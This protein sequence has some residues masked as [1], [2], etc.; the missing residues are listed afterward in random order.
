MN[1]TDPIFTDADAART[2]LESLQ[3]ANGR[4]CPHCG[5]VDN[6]VALKGKSTR[7]GVYKCRDCR[8]P[9]SVTVGTLFERSH[10]PLNKWLLAVHLLCSSKKGISSHQLMRSLGVTYKT[11]WFM[12]HRIR[13]AMRD[14]TPFPMGGEGTPVEVDEA[15]IGFDPDNMPQE[16]KQTRTGQ[17]MKV[18][19]L[20]DRSSGRAKSFV[21]DNLQIG[22]LWPILDA[23][24]AREA[25]VMT[26]AAKWYGSIFWRWNEHGVVNH[27]RDEYV[28]PTDRS[29]HTNTIEGY[30]SIF[31]RGMRGVY[32]HCAKRH[33]HRYLAEFDF[34][35]TNRMALGIDDSAR[36]AKVLSL[37]GGKRLTYRRA[38]GLTCAA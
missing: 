18:L 19:S 25:R 6:S 28:S 13:E 37:I 17:K 30:F 24:I 4:V 8:K 1:L 33:L 11:A 26:D 27:Q 38:D 31:K 14:D 20:V 10:V 32:Q 12:A 9:F 15:F 2:H 34:R 35:Y 22:T 23:N 16:G 5:T 36:A 3:W 21:V 29:I 7:P